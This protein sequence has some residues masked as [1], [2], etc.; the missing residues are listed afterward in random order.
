MLPSA[1]DFAQAM[2]RL[3]IRRDD[4]VVVYDSKEVGIF[5]APRVGWT[6]QVFG[7]P[8]VHVL[9]NFR[10]WCE[11]GYEVEQGDPAPTEAVEY[12]V[13]ELDKNMVV[14][15]EEVRDIAKDQGK[16][17]SE[18]VQILDARSSGR[19]KGTEPEPREG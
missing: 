10:K 19:F 14:D 8:N 18:E 12:A 1:E 15:F 6:L 17:G 9:N 13:P 16:E 3:G 7:H 2:G 11:D 4:S 5:S